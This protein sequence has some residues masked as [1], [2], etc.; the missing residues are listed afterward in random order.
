MPASTERL[1]QVYEYVNENPSKT[2]REIANHFDF[3]RTKTVRDYCQRYERKNITEEEESLIRELSDTGEAEA[4]EA[5]LNY[6]DKIY[7]LEYREEEVNYEIDNDYA[8]IVGLGDLHLENFWTHLDKIQ[9]DI[10]TIKKTNNLV[11]FFAGDA[12]DNPVKYQDLSFEDLA[13]PRYSRR[14]FEI[15]LNVIKNKIGGMIS[16]D[17]ERHGEEKADFDY[18][19]ELARRWDLPYLGYRGKINLKVGDVDYKVALTHKAKG[20]SEYNPFHPLVKLARKTMEFDIGLIG[21]RHTSNIAIQSVRGKQRAFLTVGSYKV[22][23]RYSRQRGY[24]PNEADL[25][26]PVLKVNGKGEKSFEI[27]SDIS[28]LH[29]KKQQTPRD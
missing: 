17:H 5:F 20:H 9:R 2:I 25:Q 22:E 27:L 8:Y 18:L 11:V 3:K 6:S 21:H 10:E 7:N 26:T 23:D 29:E 15:I 19:Q 12:T 16:G 13:P 28:C 14:F 24:S 4:W 1:K